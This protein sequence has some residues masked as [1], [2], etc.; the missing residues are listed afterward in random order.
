[1]LTGFGDEDRYILP[2]LEAG[3]KGRIPDAAAFARRQAIG[4]A[5]FFEFAPGSSLRTCSAEDLIVLK[6][7]AFR[8][9][10]LVDV[11]SVAARFGD[12]LDWIYVLDN[13][14]PL[15]AAKDEPAIMD[16]AATLRDKYA[17]KQR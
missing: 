17:K 3:Y 4:R 1:L 16:R 12:A 5:T 2:L 14:A 7:F 9:Q 15:A 6:L 8:A 10:D 11:E 13:L